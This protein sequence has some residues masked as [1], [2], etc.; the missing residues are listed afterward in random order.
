VLLDV[1]CVVGGCENFGL[2]DIV[3]T[4]GFEDL[5]GLSASIDL[6]AEG[7]H[8]WHSTKWPIRAFAMT[9]I[10]TAAMISLIILGSDMRATPP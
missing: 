3:Y 10:V 1:V 6:E 9:G 5:R 8:T 2:V 7:E 4:N